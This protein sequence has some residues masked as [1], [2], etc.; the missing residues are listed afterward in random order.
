[1]INASAIQPT[2]GDWRR[3]L[4]QA[5]REPAELATALGL[6]P[7]E[8]PAMTGAAADF[9]LLVPRGFAARMRRGDPADPLLRQVLPDALELAPQPTDYLADPLAEAAAA[10]AP[11]LLHKYH[12]RALLVTSGACAVHCRYCFRRHFPYPAENPRREDWNTALATIAADASIA[13][14]I[15][16]GGD[17]LMLDDAVLASL[18]ERLAAIAHVRRLRIHT[19]LPVVLPERVNEP[20]LDFLRGCSLPVTM[21]LHVNHPREIGPELAAACTR[22]RPHLRFLLNQAVLLADVNDDAETLV[23]LSEALD[24]IGVLPYYLH[25]PDRVAGT[26]HFAVSEERG[27]QLIEALRGRLPGYLVPRLARE[28]PGAASKLVIA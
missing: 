14:V 7:D 22:L 20:F 5:I 10:R 3:E 4:A 12:G 15:L 18:A 19:R 8:L 27:R 9:R 28:V 24:E 6:D 23:A 13:E 26:A 2:A 17:P 16:S 21:V 25:L 11:G 1:M